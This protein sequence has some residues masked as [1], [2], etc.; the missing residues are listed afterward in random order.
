M[1]SQE[2][3]KVLLKGRSLAKKQKVL[4]NGRGL[5]KKI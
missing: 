5:V 2:K 1:F 4:L 3:I